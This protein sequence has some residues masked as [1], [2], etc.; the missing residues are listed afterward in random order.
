M[1][2]SSGFVGSD[3][4]VVTF[5]AT[6]CPI[7]MAP[8]AETIIDHLPSAEVDAGLIDIGALRAAPLR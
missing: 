5:H 1:S 3:V 8:D 2:G 7:N 6:A 4:T